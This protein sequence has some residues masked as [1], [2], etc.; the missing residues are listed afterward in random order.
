MKFLRLI[1]R[2]AAIAAVL[3]VGAL[4]STSV[5]AAEK[6]KVAA[7]YTLPVEQQWVSRIHKALNAAQDRGEIEYLYSENVANNDYERV[8]REYAEQGQLELIYAQFKSGDHEEAIG[9][10]DRFI[11]L[12]PQHPNVD[13]AFYVKGLSEISQS[14]GF[15][16]NFIPTDNTK[17]DIGSAREAFA[18][19]TELLSRF[20]KSE[21]AP[22]A[23]KRLV[24]LRNNLARAEIHVANYYFARGAYLAAANRGRYVVE[25]FQQSPAVPDG[26][27][28][29]AQAYNILEMQ[30][31]ADNAVRVLVA[32]YPEH[33]SLDAMGNF[34]YD[35]RLL[36]RENSLLGKL[37]FGLIDPVQPPAFDSRH[38]YNKVAR[39]AGSTSDDGKKQSRSIWSRLTFGLMD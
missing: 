12:H 31:L 22:D 36:D 33:P 11:R 16:D 1:T 29:M 24:N 14:S 32:N 17:R 2:R 19:L 38:I 34:D 30:E 21:Y 23:R 5:A 10:A 39:E 7:I 26:L 8:M 3:S 9:S 37:T 6:L 20:P 35:K 4:T 25:N 18:T 27:A 28:V 13:Y 15:F